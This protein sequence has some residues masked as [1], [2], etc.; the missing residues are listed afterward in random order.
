M[1]ISPLSCIGN[2]S[3]EEITDEQKQKLAPLINFKQFFKLA[4][5]DMGIKIR[6]NC[7]N[8]FSIEFSLYNFF[9]LAFDPNVI[10]IQKDDVQDFLGALNDALKKATPNFFSSSQ[11]NWKREN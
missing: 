6:C 10:E 5:K 4:A 3:E 8:L 7:K 1:G 9:L 11:N 2:P